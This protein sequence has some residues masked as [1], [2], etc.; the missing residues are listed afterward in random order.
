MITPHFWTICIP[1][2]SHPVFLHLVNQ[3]I[4][5]GKPLMMFWFLVLQFVV[6]FCVDCCV[7]LRVLQ[8]RCVTVACTVKNMAPSEVQFACDIIKV[9]F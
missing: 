1:F 5:T 3:K 6:F 7:T 9:E 4:M 8:V 2:S